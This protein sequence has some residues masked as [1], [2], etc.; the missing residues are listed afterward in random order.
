MLN[1]LSPP[2]G[3]M[4]G[5]ARPCAVSCI[6]K[7]KGCVEAVGVVRLLV[8]S[9]IVNDVM[10]NMEDVFQTMSIVVSALADSDETEA[11]LCANV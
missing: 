11:E 5:L 10:L 8:E 3:H 4:L 2:S 7:T 9:I 1:T 6:T